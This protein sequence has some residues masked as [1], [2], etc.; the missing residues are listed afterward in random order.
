MTFGMYLDHVPL[1]WG[2]SCIGITVILGLILYWIRLSQD[3]FPVIWSIID[4]RAISVQ[5]RKRGIIRT[6]QTL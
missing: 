6:Q 3:Y 4:P 2:S 5:M 1:I